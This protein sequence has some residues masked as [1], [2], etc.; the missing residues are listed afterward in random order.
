MGFPE[1]CCTWVSPFFLDLEHV[2]QHNFLSTVFVVEISTIKLF[3]LVDWVSCL[4]DSFVHGTAML[5]HFIVGAELDAHLE[6]VSNARTYY[7]KCMDTNNLD[8]F[9]PFFDPF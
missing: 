5:V 9:L 1:A 3:K 7:H 8:E 6:T 4:Y 2:I